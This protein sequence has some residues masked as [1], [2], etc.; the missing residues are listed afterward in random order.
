M[1]FPTEE[2][3]VLKNE[4]NDSMIKLIIDRWMDT[5]VNNYEHLAERNVSIYN[6][7]SQCS[8]RS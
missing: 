4:M 7:I 8:R 2:M 1:E 6:V 5:Q 3:T